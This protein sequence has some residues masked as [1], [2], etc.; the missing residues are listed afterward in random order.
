M[1]SCLPVTKATIHCSM[2]SFMQGIRTNQWWIQFSQSGSNGVKFA[3]WCLHCGNMVCN[4]L[5]ALFTS[6]FFACN[7]VLQYGGYSIYQ[8]M[9]LHYVTQL[10]TICSTIKL[11]WTATAIIYFNFFLCINL[12][13]TSYFMSEAELLLSCK[14]CITIN[15]A[16]KH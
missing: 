10:Q 6:A 2:L 13:I 3:E 4:F 8:Q 15:I 11:Y 1:H 12:L 14:V 16:N 5:Q 7:C 9:K